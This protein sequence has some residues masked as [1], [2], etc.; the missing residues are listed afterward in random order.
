MRYTIPVFNPS[1]I[2]V[3]LSDACSAVCLHMAHCENE[4]AAIV[5]KNKSE[6]IFLIGNKG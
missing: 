2:P 5:M 4:Y 6:I 3:L 1:A